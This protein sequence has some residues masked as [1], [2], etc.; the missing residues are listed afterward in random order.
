MDTLA[1]GEVART[2]LVASVRGPTSSTQEVQWLSALQH[3][4]LS[5]LLI[6][7]VPVGVSF[8]CCLMDFIC[9]SLMNNMSVVHLGISCEVP[10]R[11]LSPRSDLWGPPVFLIQVLCGH[12][13]L[14]VSSLS[15]A[16]RSV[17]EPTVCVGCDLNLQ[18]E[19][20]V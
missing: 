15:L 5:F 16:P 8:V 1:P 13:A 12:C 10:S 2:L 19:V 18:L 14:H 7:A 20:S 17:L 6:S 11:G 9:I 3:L 4:T